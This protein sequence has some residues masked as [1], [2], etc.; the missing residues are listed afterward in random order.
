MKFDKPLILEIKQIITESPRVKSFVFDYDFPG[1]PGQFVMAWI[2][3]HDEKPFG[4]V[5]KAG[6][7]MITV[8]GVG[9]STNALHAMKEGERVG[10]RGP[11]GT[12][13]TLPDAGT[14]ALVA[15]GYGIAPLAYLADVAR[16]KG[17]EVHLFLGARSKEELV[18]SSWMKEIGVHCHFA[19]DDGTE[20]FK[21]YNTEL[22]KEKISELKPDKVFVV[23]PEVMEMK[24]TQLCYEQNI[25]F[26]VSLER[27][28][29]CAIG[30]CG[31]C[32]V[33]PTGWRMCVE[34]PVLDQDQLKKVEEYGK[35]HRTAS[36][37][38]I[39]Y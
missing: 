18:F 21:G 2:P 9:D 12:S 34:G 16:K 29:K 13:F 19:T 23:G 33:D 38:I 27:Y 32:S 31:Q 26:Q 10:M 14:I 8:A 35:Y 4:I 30:L 24:V 6:Q 36:G 25:P 5:K 11:Y 20:G 37:K 7:F 28:M 1:E 22:F 3:G 17:I 39:H 15:G